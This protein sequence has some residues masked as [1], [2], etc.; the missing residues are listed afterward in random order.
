V[1]LTRVL[2]KKVNNLIIVSTACL[3]SGATVLSW[4]AVR[5]GGGTIAVAI[6]Y[7]FISG[8]LVSVPPVTVAALSKNR[9]EYSTRMGMAFT[10]CSF[11]TLV[12]NPIAGALLV[13]MRNAGGKQLFLGPCLFAGGT[14]ISAAALSVGAYYLHNK[15]L[16]HSG[17]SGRDGSPERR[18]RARWIQSLA[19]EA[20]TMQGATFAL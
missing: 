4:L 1:E 17:N 13:S 10:V 15:G 3:L 5:N 6:M 7:G 2:R 16:G 8:G 18:R 12:G 20:L 14:M 19:N 9:D 11:G